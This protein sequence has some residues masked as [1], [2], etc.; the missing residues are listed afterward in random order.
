MQKT[1][2]RLGV[3]GILLVGLVLG[4]GGCDG[5]GGGPTGPT[6]AP[7]LSNITARPNPAN[8]GATIIFEIGFVDVPGDLN[9][10]TAV[11]TDSQGN[12]YQGLVSNAEGTSGTLVTSIA[13][14]PLVTPGDLLF[15]VFVI[16]LAGN[17][18]NTV[19]VT[20]TIS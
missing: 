18:S 20:I 8:P 17:S 14:S 15:N 4:L 13:L 5:G 19:F 6:N 9:G 11:V 1:G 3:L 10:G 7:V 2:M 16:D 12:S